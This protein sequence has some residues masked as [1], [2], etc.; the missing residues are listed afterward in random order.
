MVNPNQEDPYKKRT[1]QDTWINEDL[2]H[3]ERTSP[4]RNECQLYTTIKTPK[5]SQIKVRII[6]SSSGTLE[7]WEFSNLTFGRYL[8]GTTPILF[9]SSSLFLSHRFCLE[10]MRTVWLTNDFWHH[11]WKPQFMCIVLYI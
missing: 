5:P 8:A 3:K 6:Y 2:P 10:H 4:P 11:T 1:L 9:A 7:L